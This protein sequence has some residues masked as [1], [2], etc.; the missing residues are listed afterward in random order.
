[1]YTLIAF[2]PLLDR[3]DSSPNVCFVF[4]RISS[5]SFVDLGKQAEIF[6]W[7]SQAMEDLGSNDRFPS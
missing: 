1:M 3:S 7:R 5:E 6:A 4:L 2:A